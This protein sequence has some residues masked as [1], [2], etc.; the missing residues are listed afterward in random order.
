MTCFAREAFH[1]EWNSLYGI[2]H[3]QVLVDS[4]EVITLRIVPTS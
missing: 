2:R 4:F 3:V 1:V